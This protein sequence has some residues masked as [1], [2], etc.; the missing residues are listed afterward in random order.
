MYNVDFLHCRKCFFAA[1]GTVM[2]DVGIYAC[3]FVYKLKNGTKC[4]DRISITSN[5]ARIRD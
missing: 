1:I 4:P 2:C 5:L 3:D